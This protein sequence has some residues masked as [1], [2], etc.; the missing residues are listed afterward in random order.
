MS[1]TGMTAGKLVSKSRC[2]CG[3]LR[4]SLYKVPAPA[5]YR[6]VC[7][8]FTVAKVTDG[9]YYH[10]VGGGQAVPPVI[11]DDDSGAH[12]IECGEVITVPD[13]D[14][15]PEKP[16]RMGVTVSPTWMSY[17]LELKSGFAARVFISID[18]DTRELVR[19][20]Q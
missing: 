8:E 18:P 16:R 11:S 4:V 7:T 1:N 20:R 2:V 15:S 9:V 13:F 3:Q 17:D 6:E 12:C 19:V 10:V 5:R 14:V